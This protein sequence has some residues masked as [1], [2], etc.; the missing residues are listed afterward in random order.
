MSQVT[1]IQNFEQLNNLIIN[2]K[3][4]IVIDFNADWC[5]PC[6]NIKPKF[7]DFSKQYKNVTFCS[8]DIDD[9]DEIGEEF[10]ITNLPT[11]LFT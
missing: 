11:F 2:N 10:G 6:Q 3:Q 5:G 8:V 4:L 7:H 9:Q 1:E